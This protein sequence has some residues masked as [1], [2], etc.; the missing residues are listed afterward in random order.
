MDGDNKINC[1]QCKIKRTCHKHLI[2][3]SLPNILVIALKRFE[4]DY[5]TM[6]KYKLN[7]YF[8]FPHKLDMKDYLIENHKET[9]TEYELTGITIHFGISDFGHYYDLIKGPDNKWYKFND[10]SVSEFK[11]EDIPKEAFGEKEILDEDSYKEKE[12]GKNNAYILIYKKKSFGIEPIDKKIKQDLALQPYSKYSNINDE[13]KNEINFKLYK[14]WTLNIIFNPAYQ[15]FIVQL[16]EL[17]LAKI[18]DPNIEKNHSQL[19]NLIK[20]EGIEID[21]NKDSNNSDSNN[22]IFEFCLR[23]FFNVILRISRRQDKAIRINYFN[24]FKDII[25]T[26]TESDIKKAKYLLEEF[27]NIEAIEEFLIYCPIPDSLNDSLEIIYNA[28]CV[29]YKKTSNNS[30]DT[31]IYEFLDTLIIYIDAKIREINLETINILLMKIIE[32]DLNRFINY[33][34]KKNFQRWVDSFYETRNNNKKIINENMYPTIHSPHS[35]LTDKT[36]KN[37][38]DKK[39]LN[40]ESDIYDQHFVNKI[41][42]NSVNRNLI[43]F[44]AHYFR[45]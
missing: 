19:V 32:I 28:F 24:V 43:E 21:Y 35:I 13:I 25:K 15:N 3:K 11:E 6:L 27:S 8:E 42:D 17:D 20:S 36:Y 39:L 26:Y 41:R 10:I 9:N 37:N 5:N 44:F 18:I 14:S 45:D 29:V 16:L 38:K 2:F 34:N 1:E 22:K 4:F 31:F 7:K 33:L 12:N 23:Y 30:N 40:E